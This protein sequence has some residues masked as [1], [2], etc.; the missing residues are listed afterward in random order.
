MKKIGILTTFGAWDEAYSPVNVV[1]HQLEMLKRYDYS[2]VLFV[3]DV[4]PKDFAIEGVEIRRVLPTTKFEPYHG[5]VH[6]R[7][8]PPDFEKDIARIVPVFEEQFKDIDVMLCHDVIFQDSFLPYN[9]ALHKMVHPKDIKYYHWMHSGPSI[10]PKVDY[11]ISCLYSLPPKSKLIYMNRYDVVRAA[12][13]YNT[14][15]S[16]VR[17][18]HNPIDYRLQLKLSPITDRIISEFGLNDADIVAVYPLSTTRMGAGGKQLHKAIKVMAGLKKLGNSVRLIVPNAHANGAKE[19]QEIENMRMLAARY[20]LDPRF[21]IVFTSLLGK[22]YEGGI[23]HDSVVELIRYSD[24][25]L[26]PSVSENCPLVLLEAGLGKNLM[27]LNEDFSPMKDF[28]G[29]NALYFKFDSVTTTTSHDGYP[30][31]EDGYFE[32]V[33]KIINAELVNNKVHLAF[34]DI[35]K[36]FNIDYIFKKQVEPLFFEDWT[37]KVEQPEDELLQLPPQGMPDILEGGKKD[38]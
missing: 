17:V 37:Q 32:D 26:F 11:P 21:E 10:R 15:Q 23:P 35:K 19:K 38:A 3:L 1:T 9:A 25:F 2:P 16:N 5:I 14:M 4:F 29:P 33:A 6:H 18:V 13:M 8:V 20:E 36:K 30:N 27:V 34:N 28:V 22:E 24:I 12:E 7:Q 31:G